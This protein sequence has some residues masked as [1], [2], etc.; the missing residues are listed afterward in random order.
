MRLSGIRR[1]DPPHNPGVLDTATW[2]RAAA[3]RTV[4]RT[5][6]RWA[7][8]HDGGVVG[9]G[10]TTYGGSAVR[11]GAAQFL[12]AGLPDGQQVFVELGRGGA[13]LGTPLGEMTLKSG[14]RQCGSVS[15]RCGGP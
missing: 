10:V 13:A 11:R 14:L 7:A 3:S 8:A 12:L 1:L 9:G 2:D 4:G 15:D 5:G 6:E